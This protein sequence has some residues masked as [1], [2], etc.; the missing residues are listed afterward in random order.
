MNNH[1]IKLY[2]QQAHEKVIDISPQEMQSK[3]KLRQHFTP[4]WM[5]TIKETD[6]AKC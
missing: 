2:S 3:T 6:I 5:V 1:T 4:T